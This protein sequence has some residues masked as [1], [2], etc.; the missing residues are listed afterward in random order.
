MKVQ[1]LIKKLFGE[2]AIQDYMD[3]LDEEEQYSVLEYYSIQRNEDDSEPDYFV[4]LF[5]DGLYT[6]KD[7]NGNVLIHTYETP[8]LKNKLKVLAQ[9]SN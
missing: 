6:I 9:S 1:T 3:T 8:A 2:N 4:K 7:I 5:V